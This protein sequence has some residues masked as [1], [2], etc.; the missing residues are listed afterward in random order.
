MRCWPSRWPCSSSAAAVWEALWG[1]T[2]IITGIREPFS[3]QPGG[4]QWGLWSGLPA[5][6]NPMAAAPGLRP[7]IQ[8]S[9]WC[10]VEVA[11]PFGL[12]LPTLSSVAVA[13]LL[14]ALDL[15]RGPLEGGADLVGLQLGHRP[16]LPLGGL[17]GPLPQPA[18]D[19]VPGLAAPHVDLEEV[20]L[21]VAPL[22]IL[23]DPLGDRCRGL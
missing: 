1:S 11:A 20:G 10:V 12:P 14:S 9:R 17:P 18:G 6:W 5:P 15:G 4:W 3:S 21:A 2:P 19:Q 13:A 22:A 8:L 16:L 7:R 23:L